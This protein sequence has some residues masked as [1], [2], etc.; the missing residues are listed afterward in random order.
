MAQDI[1]TPTEECLKNHRK[2]MMSQAEAHG[3]DITDPKLIKYIEHSARVLAAQSAAA[4][5]Y[6]FLLAPG[7]EDD[8]VKNHI[9]HT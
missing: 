1:Y 2:G 9:R 5:F 3:L 8:E 7:R 4:S 6:A